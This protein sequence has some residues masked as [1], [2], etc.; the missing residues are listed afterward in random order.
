MRNT[1]IV[2]I[3]LAI[4]GIAYYYYHNQKLAENNTTPDMN[5]VENKIEALEE[6]SDFVLHPVS[7]ASFMLELG[8]TLIVNDPVGDP[9]AFMGSGEADIILLS[10]THGDHLNVETLEALVGEGTSLVA[11]QVVYDE[12]SETLKEKTAIMKNGEV[13]SVDNNQLIIE[14]I[15]MYNLPMEGPDYRHVKGEG[16][17]YVIT[18]GETRVYIA[19]DTEDIEEMR[20]LED[21]DYA[22]VPMNLPY[23]MDVEKAADG[24]LAFAPRVV[25]PY[26]YRGPDG[27]SDV[28]EFKR[29]VNASNPDIEVRLADWYPDSDDATD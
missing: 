22:F 27:L 7:H 13:L 10:H 29:L 6:S 3:I 14:A 5:T 15:P 1:I 21:I 17:G 20:A 8:D 9:A 19:G 23:T 18:R 24:V 12:L 4:G 28:E 25:Y 2:F 16:N 11:P 26:H